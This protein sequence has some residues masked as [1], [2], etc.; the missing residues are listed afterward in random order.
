[1]PEF[2]RGGGGGGMLK[3][4][5]DRRITFALWLL[6]CTVKAV[7]NDREDKRYAGNDK[8]RNE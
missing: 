5:F 2:A 1:M 3:F 8:G 6:C 7:S 4:R